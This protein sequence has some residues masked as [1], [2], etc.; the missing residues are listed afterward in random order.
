MGAIATTNNTQ[1]QFLTFRLDEVDYAVEVEKTREILDLVSITR[2]PQMPAAMLGVINLRG[3]AVPVIDLRRH[4][5]LPVTERTRENCIILLEVLANGATM[6]VG[7][8]ADAVSEVL[9]LPESEIEPPPRLGMQLHRDFIQGMG[10]K[11]G[12]FLIILDLDR[13]FSAT[14]LDLLQDALPG[15]A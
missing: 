3:G 9:E 10:K 7:A 2:M 13:V 4:F 5:G 6:V 12:K 8:L 15:A 1:Q 11:D 14:E